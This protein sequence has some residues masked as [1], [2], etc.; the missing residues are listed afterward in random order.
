MSALAQQRWAI[1][2]V[3]AGLLAMALRL[4]AGLLTLLLLWG[5]WTLTAHTVEVTVD[6]MTER[7]STHRH[8]VGALLLDLGLE[9]T[10]QDRVAPG[11]ETPI[12]DQLRLQVLRARPFRILADGREVTV[13]S[14]GQTAQE[15]FADAR[16][17]IDPNDRVIL[18]DQELLPTDPLPQPVVT[19]A[20]QTY[21]RGRAWQRLTVEP[22]QLRIH[23]SLPLTVDD[24]NLPF[25]IRT[26]ADTVGE[27]LREAE[28][29]LYL[30]DRVQPSL[31]SQVSSGLRVFIQR[32]TP[33]ALAL[34][35]RVIKTRTRAQ[36]VGDALAEL[37]VG[38]TGADI[39]QPALDEPVRPDLQIA[40]TRVREEIAVSEEIIPFETFFEPDPNLEID[41]QQVVNDGAPGINRQRFRVRYE[42]G[43]EVARE[44]LDSWVAQEATQRVIA[45]GQRIEPKTATA[46][47]GTQI[48]YWR[49][50]RVYA[51]SYSA[52]TAGVSRDSPTYGRTY[53]GEQMRTG[54]VAVDP[55]TIPLHS[56][57]YIPGYGYG[58]ALDTGS[59]ILGRHIDLGYAD[60]ELVLWSRWVDIYLLWP[61]PP[62]HQITWVLPNYP[63]E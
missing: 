48:T 53:T 52:A 54:I 50:M 3:P 36:T 34:D 62:S 25:I 28:I 2:K 32:S 10:P 37:K 4:A 58:D 35:G 45:Y 51:S 14:W 61:P 6:G 59:A 12:T 5:G 8:T 40:I 56:K 33:I 31:G 38:V 17:A 44:L 42:N 43:K 11:V 9:L 22:V 20:P 15:V 30:G 49:R 21:D 26:T 46:P 7:V 1:R 39:V 60:D 23:R 55:R 47:D 16:L 19:L 29:T 24:G 13:T 27:A 63:R 41:T 18:G 57:L